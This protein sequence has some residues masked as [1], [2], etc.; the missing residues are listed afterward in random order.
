[1]TDFVG[2]ASSTEV[3]ADLFAALK[4]DDTTRAAAHLDDAIV[5]H[6]VG[7]P[8][9]RGI[10][11]VQKAISALAKPGFGF[12]VKIHNIAADES[13][14][15]VLTERTD[16]L[17]WRRVRVEFWVCG[18]FEMQNGKITVWRDYFDNLDFG[19]AVARGLVKALFAR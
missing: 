17:I 16:T 9:V 19:R 3:V 15:I 2:I 7:M 11:R 6:N 14:Q 4:E 10:V 1:M 8:K 5:W 18:T 13:G 12:D